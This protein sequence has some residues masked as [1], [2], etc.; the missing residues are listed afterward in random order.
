MQHLFEW[1]RGERKRKG[2]VL[3]LGGGGGRGLAHLGV[4]D[5]LE[6]HELRPD[7]IVGSSIGALFGAMYAVHPDSGELKQRIL[8]FLDSD[9]TFGSLNLPALSSVEGAE[10]EDQTWLSRLTAAARQSILF[11]RVATDIAVADVDKLIDIC[12]TLCD[13]D[14][15]K[16]AKIPLYI[17]AVQFPSGECHIFSKDTKGSLPC[18][19]AASMA[20]PGVF[21]P[22]KVGG[23]RFLDGGIASE[24]P[25]KEAKMIA[26]PGQIAVAVNVGSRP[27]PDN[28]PGNVI[29]MLDWATR[30]KAL[31]LRQYKK[32]HADVLIEPLVGFTQWHD[33]SNP[34]QEIE[35][36]RQAAL[37]QIPKLLKLVGG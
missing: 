30:I 8:S 22:V 37:E 18:A 36:G 11:T 27:S 28:E 10:A 17:T 19:I 31:Y 3:A 9:E 12:H 34:D 21:D 6:A 20:V 4:L 29:G 13:A 14:S 24:L 33:F 26:M 15:F 25:A 2:F 1:M 16:E 23:E 35:R 32:E 5:V 7:A